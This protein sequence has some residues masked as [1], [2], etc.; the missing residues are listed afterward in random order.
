MR[1][2]I[3]LKKGED[4]WFTVT[5][6]SLS[7]CIS[8]GRTEDEAKRNMREAIELHIKSLAEDGLPLR[9]EPNEKQAVIS[10][11]V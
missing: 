10:I 11:K 9:S 2:K 1:F 6:P 4:G 8:Q 5:C 3:I 7:G